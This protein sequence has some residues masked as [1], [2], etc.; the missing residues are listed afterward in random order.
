MVITCPFVQTTQDSQI[1][2]KYIAGP[3]VL[4]RVNKLL[5]NYLYL[6]A[7]HIMNVLVESEKQRGWKIGDNQKANNRAKNQP[8]CFYK[9]SEHILFIDTND[10]RINKE[11]II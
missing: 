8:Y 11:V 3:Y 1:R 5:Y 7:Q 4:G 6:G 9:F 10:N 2:M